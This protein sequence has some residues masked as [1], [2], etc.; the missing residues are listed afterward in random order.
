M[1][2][3]HSVSNRFPG[4]KSWRWSR[5]SLETPNLHLNSLQHTTR[6]N[7]YICSIHIFVDF[8]K[9]KLIINLWITKWTIM[10]T[11]FQQV[12]T[13]WHLPLAQFRTN[14]SIAGY[15]RCSWCLVVTCSGETPSIA[16]DLGIATS[17]CRGP[18]GLQY[19]STGGHRRV[20]GCCC[21]CCCCCCEFKINWKPIFKM[22]VYL[23]YHFRTLTI[24]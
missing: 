12:L 6:T 23:E 20:L 7:L 22:I 11:S 14:P 18:W 1:G 2:S 8:Q 15:R 4:M 21:C 5:W 16:C 19:P 24:V 3:P 10:N 17:S 9:I 13:W